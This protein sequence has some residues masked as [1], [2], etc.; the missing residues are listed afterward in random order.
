MIG[1]KDRRMI[2]YY[3]EGIINVSIIY[4]CYRYVKWVFSEF[5]AAKVRDDEELRKVTETISQNN[6]G[7]HNLHTR[8]YSTITR[9]NFSKLNKKRPVYWSNF[10]ILGR[11]II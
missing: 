1:P 11:K 2:N 3:L 7:N 4:G 9:I 6:K 8:A 5:K 10:I